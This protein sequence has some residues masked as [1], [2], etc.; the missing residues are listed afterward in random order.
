[1][2][3]KSEC[4]VKIKV[5]RWGPGSSGHNYYLKGLI[6]L[7]CPN[8]RPQLNAVT[9]AGKIERCEAGAPLDGMRVFLPMSVHVRVCIPMQFFF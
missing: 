2:I 9:F 3:G 4:A 1:M 6:K 5:E 7:L 8:K